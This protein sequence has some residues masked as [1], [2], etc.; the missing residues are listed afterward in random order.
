MHP[1]VFVAENQRGEMV[2]RGVAQRRFVAGRGWFAKQ[3]TDAR[4][5]G[6]R[7]QLPV[8]ACDGI[9]AKQR[10][11]VVVERRGLGMRICGRENDLLLKNEIVDPVVSID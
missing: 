2:S 10:S 9:Q 7:D 4:V 5:G 6:V 8:L 1:A 3:R 11:P